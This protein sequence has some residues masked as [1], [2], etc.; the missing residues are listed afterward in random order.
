MLPITSRPL[1]PLS[2]IFYVT[3]LIQS[4]QLACLF[5][6]SLLMKSTSCFAQSSPESTFFATAAEEAYS[7]YQMPGNG[8]LWPSCWADDGNLYTANGDGTAFSGGSTIY[9]M[10]VS[11]IHGMP[12]SLTGTTIATDVGTNWSGPGYNRK[13]TGML[14]INDRIYLAFQNLD[15]SNFNDAPAASIA[16]SNDHGATWTWDTSAPMFG[17][18][19]NPADPDAY[20]FTTIF[21][22]DFGQNSDHA[23]DNYVYAYGLDNNWRSQQALYLARVP[24]TSILDRST[25]EFYAG[26]DTSGA[27]LWSPDITQKVPVLVDTRLLYPV[28]F[29]TDCPEN[30]AVIAQGGVV[31]DAPLQR[32]I[33]SSWS[34]ATH[35][36]YEAPA[37][38]GP[39]RH[40]LSNDFGPL[41]LPQNRGQYGTSIP[42]KFISSD[43]K[44]FYLQSNV[45]CSGDSYTFSLRKIFLQPVQQASPSNG[46]SNANLAT[47]PGTRAVS[48]STHYGSLCGFGCSDLLNSGN[49]SE[50]EDDYDE[51]SKTSDW[52]GCIWPVPYNVNQLVYVTGNV[53]Q[54]GGW[55][56]ANLQVQVRQNFQ[57]VSVSNLVVTPDYPYNSSAGAFTT[58]SF[59][60]SDT[61]GDGIRIIGTPGGT[62]HFTSINQLRV[63]Y[64]SGPVTAPDF[65]LGNSG[66]IAVS[67]GAATG[68][69]STITVTPSG[70]FTGTVNLSCA[71]TTSIANPAYLP[72]CAIPPSV[73]IAGDAPQTATLTIGTTAPGPSPAVPNRRSS[74]AVLAG[75]LWFAMFLGCRGRRCR[76]QSWFRL[77]LLLFISFG[78]GCGGSPGSQTNLNKQTGTSPGSY[79]VTVTGTSNTI[80]RTTVVALTVQ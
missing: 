36:F 19:G 49:S 75:G 37:P 6:L 11:V 74:Y 54:D 62:S 40:F 13:P 23:I 38:W 34:C 18:P 79:V 28:M 3:L 14:C 68:N 56:S 78:V 27:P 29:G 57:W 31:Y 33:F 2:R 25:W 1:F 8:D 39:W 61:W 77:A 21:F 69:T 73:T 66:G 58:Y 67:P 4:L 45:C 12:P 44:T 52:W 42:S 15:S 70:G 51:E 10:A 60:F 9:D 5:G 22:L 59:S 50:S 17:T 76:I 41:R 43:G 20:K 72:T 80:T 30:Q 55:F 35:E 47:A 64:A 24:A 26:A 65:G 7:T 48:K 16:E 53:F 46:L 63:Y 71:V 32:Y